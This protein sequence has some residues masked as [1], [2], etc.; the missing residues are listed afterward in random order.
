M[1]C[2]HADPDIVLWSWCQFLRRDLLP[3]QRV[4]V[5]FD[6]STF[7]AAKARGLAAPRA[8]PG[9]V[10]PLDPGFGDDLVV[11]RPAG[12]RALAHGSACLDGGPAVWWDYVTGP[13]ALVQVLPTWNAGP[14]ANAAIRVEHGLPVADPA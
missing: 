14:A 8:P 2:E 3:D 11:S 5:R 6:C 12:V 1:T 13:Q 7:R 10:L 9:R 4:V